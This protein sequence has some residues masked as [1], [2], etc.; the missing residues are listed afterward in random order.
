MQ[1]NI[2]T[3]NDQGAFNAAAA[4]LLTQ[5]FGGCTQICHRSATAPRGAITHS[6][7]VRII[8]SGGAE[9]G[10]LDIV[11]SSPGGI[12]PGVDQVQFGSIDPTPKPSFFVLTGVP[13]RVVGL[14][15]SPQVDR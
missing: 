11:T 4:G 10:S 3:Y 5:T 1:A 14:R 15:A 2:S 9:I 6:V 7:T 13:S 12:T 8:T